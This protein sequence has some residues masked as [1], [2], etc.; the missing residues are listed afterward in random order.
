MATVIPT[1][2]SILPDGLLHPATHPTHGQYLEQLGNGDGDELDVVVVDPNGNSLHVKEEVKEEDGEVEED[3]GAG[4]APMGIEER[5]ALLRS[6]ISG[7][8]ESTQ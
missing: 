2:S 3:G 6:Q 5:L 8:L 7:E 1:T 4:V